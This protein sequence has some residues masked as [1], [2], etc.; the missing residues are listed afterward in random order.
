MVT[1]GQVKELKRLLTHGK[2]LRFAARMTEMTDKTARKFRGLDELPS[3][4]KKQRSYRTRED[5]FVDVWDVV[6]KRLHHEPKLKAIT[7]FHWLQKEHPGEFF[8]SSRR[9][10]ER[11]VASW[12]A[13]NGPEKTVFFAQVH[14][15]GTLAAS[16][17]TVCNELDVKIA[18]AQFDHTFFHCVLTYSNTES[19]SLCFSESFESLSGGIQKAFW[20]FGGVPDV[21][22]T[23]SLSAATRNHTSKKQLTERYAAL[24][25]HYR[26]EPHRTNARSPNENGDIESSNGHFKDRLDQALL[27]RGS[28]D[29]PSRQAYLDFVEELVAAA[30]AARADRFAEDQAALSPLPDAWLDTDDTMTGVRVSPSCTI[31]VRTNTYSVP[32][33]LIGHRVDVRIGAE[34]LEVLYQG[35]SVQVMPRLTGK[36]NASINYRHIIDSLVRK[37]GAFAAYRYRDELFPTTNFRIAYDLLHSARSEKEADRQ[38]LK[39][40]DLAA[41]ESQDA[42]ADAL[43]HLIAS[44]EAIDFNRVNELVLD[45]SRIPA[46]TEVDVPAPDLAEF[47]FLIPSMNKECSQDGQDNINEE[48][49]ATVSVAR[50]EQTAEQTVGFANRR[51]D[52]AVEGTAST[53]DPRSIP[54]DSSASGDRRTQSHGVSFGADDKGMRG[55]PR[56][57]SEASDDSQQASSGQDLGVAG[58][59]SLSTCGEQPVGSVTG[60]E[61]SGSTREHFDFRQTGQWEESCLVRA[62]GASD[63]PGS[64]HAVHDLQSVGAATVDREAGLATAAVD[65]NAW[66]LRGLDH[67]RPGL[68]ATGPRGN[69]GVVHVACRTLRTRERS[70]DEQLGVQQM[71]PDLQRCDDDSS[72][73]RPLGASQRDHRNERTELPCGDGKEENIRGNSNCR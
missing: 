10:F 38:Y 33:R 64:Q 71:G 66:E 2:S 58:D 46:P 57:T 4:T 65:Q 28:R 9:T 16:D 12:R 43:R 8:D 73:D 17:F 49:N 62:G 44:S 55:S 70:A 51:A 19:V 37:P 27:L 41:K 3:Q 26:C 48:D 22:R 21:H 23:D 69:G 11:R 13:L 31:N 61:F 7:L 14:Q 36:N 24:M 35:I 68:R 20:Q 29:F 30:N 53:N 54:A 56:G 40:L 42:V 25:D 63:S 6:E 52:D 47:D 18:G 67:R 50:A 45:A 5:P 34:Q 39:I 72:G 1:D 32:S 15:P 59:R 60:R